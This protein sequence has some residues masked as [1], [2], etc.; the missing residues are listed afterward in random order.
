MVLQHLA[1]DHD[2][3]LVEL[4]QRV[5]D[6]HVGEI[7]EGTP[8]AADRVYVAPAGHGIEVRDDILHLVYPNDGKSPSLPIDGFFRSLAIDQRERALCVVLS[9]MGSDGTEGATAVHD[10]SGYVFAQ[11]PSSAQFGAMPAA[12][13]ASGACRDTAAPE[14]LAQL[15]VE[16]IDLRRATSSGAAE[17]G[18]SDDDAGID[19]VIQTTRSRNG[20]DFSLYKRITLVRRI[21]RR[22]M[23]HGIDDTLSYA[24]HLRENPQEVDLLFSEMLIG[25][26]SFFRDPEVWEHLRIDVLPQLIERCGDHGVVRAWSAGCSTGE[27]AYSLAMSMVE[28]IEAQPTPSTCAVQIFASDLDAEAIERARTGEYP[29]TIASEISPE[30]LARFFEPVA[31][32]YRVSPTLRKHVVFATHNVLM[33]PPFSNL[34]LIVCRNLLIYLQA[35]VQRRLLTVFHRCLRENGVL[36]L[37]LAESVGSAEASFS[38]I[39]GRRHTYRHLALNEAHRPALLRFNGAAGAANIAPLSAATPVPTMQALTDHLIVTRH[40]PAAVLANDQGDIVYFSGRTGAFLEPA[41]GKANLNVFA[42]ARE[43][44]RLALHDTF[45]AAVRDQEETRVERLPLVSALGTSLVDLVVQPISSPP[46]LRGLV[47]LVFTPSNVSS[48]LLLQDTLQLDDQSLSTDDR[49]AA[50]SEEL[51]RLRAAL[52]SAAHDAQY[53]RERLQ[54]TIEEL[55]S[56]NEELTTSKEEMQSMNEELQT[57]N[58]E[59]QRRVAAL[60]LASDDMANLIT[61][62]SVAT[63]YLDNE[64]CVRRFTSATVG[65]FNLIPSDQGRPIVD[66]ASTLDHR[67]VVA[68]AREVMRTLTLSERHMGSDDGRWFNVRIAPYR[69]QDDRFDGV[70]VTFIDATEAHTAEAVRKNAL[71]ILRGEHDGDHASADDRIAAAAAVLSASTARDVIETKES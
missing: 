45:T 41:A 11:E 71:D 69:T 60:S 9:G 15:V 42:M 12:V 48:S 64:L 40:G 6:M 35:D 13:I 5:T 3:M 16:Q 29:A 70:V 31:A 61:S 49:S 22:M 1:T 30:R 21:E 56:T 38:E 4:L 43:G 23:V 66:L 55:Q 62:S 27:E 34:D 17:T 20:H 7:V 14:Q 58:N 28:A 19:A 46:E 63:L 54:A 47:L 57:V 44:I 37:G 33:D 39:P 2:S 52:Q 8:V 68:D 36:M 59:L 50:L 51:L 10:R 24:Q 67:L 32:G 53:S 25:V 65:L 26:T 18:G